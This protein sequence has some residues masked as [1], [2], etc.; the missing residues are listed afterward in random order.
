MSGSHHFFSELDT[1]I[2]GQV[3]FGDGSVTKIE[4]RRTIILACENGKH[5]ALTGLY[6][7]P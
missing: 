2:C 6:Y 3:K 7:I 1:Q 4:G 5:H